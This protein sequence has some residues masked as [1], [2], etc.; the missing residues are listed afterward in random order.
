M[1]IELGIHLIKKEELCDALYDLCIQ[2]GYEGVIGFG[3]LPKP[4]MDLIEEQIL[5]KAIK[6]SL[7]LDSETLKRVKEEVHNKGLKEVKIDGISYTVNKKKLQE[8]MKEITV[9]IMQSAKKAGK[10]VV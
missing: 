10:M 7:E 6:D 8:I 5:F 3:M 1:V 4:I 2:A 9:G